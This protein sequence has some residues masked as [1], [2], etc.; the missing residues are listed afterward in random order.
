MP[1]LPAAI[2]NTGLKLWSQESKIFYH[3]VLGLGTIPAYVGF[4]MEAAAKGVELWRGVAYVTETTEKTVVTQVGAQL[5][6]DLKGCWLASKGGPRRK[7]YYS[8]SYAGCLR[9]RF[10]HA[11]G[12]LLQIGGQSRSAELVGSHRH[13]HDPA[14]SRVA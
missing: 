1:C 10:G 9:L 14:C 13:R 8:S 11:F 6:P 7:H 4:S 12:H 2:G 3:I 5:S